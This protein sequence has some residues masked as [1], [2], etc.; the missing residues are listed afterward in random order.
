[1]L[2]DLLLRKMKF[3][4]KVLVL[5]ILTAFDFQK[6]PAPQ[7]YQPVSWTLCGLIKNIHK[8]G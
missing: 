5:S 3:T 2:F 4:L 7:Y 1:M 8:Q 6:F